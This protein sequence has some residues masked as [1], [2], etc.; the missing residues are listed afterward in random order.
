MQNKPLLC[1]DFDDTIWDGYKVIQGCIPALQK[2]SS[3]YTIGIFSARATESERNQMKG[4]LD[5][6]GVP[7]DVILPP[8]PN[9]V[10][11]ID[12]KGVHFTSWDKIAF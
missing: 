8:K 9:A 7:Y 12:D 6:E 3:L 5:S 4:I 1:V 11:F 2:F 10:A